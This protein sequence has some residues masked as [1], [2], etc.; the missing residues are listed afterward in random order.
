MKSSTIQHYRWLFFNSA[1]QPFNF[2]CL[3]PMTSN[4]YFIYGEKISFFHQIVSTT[5]LSP[6]NWNVCGQHWPAKRISFYEL[7]RN[8]KSR[9]NNFGT[10]EINRVVIKSFSR[11]KMVIRLFKSNG[12]PSSYRWQH[13]SRTYPVAHCHQKENKS[14]D[15]N[16]LT[17][18]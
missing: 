11:G 16:N 15:S 12:A 6:K 1:K 5:I 8:D 14:T 2:V 18:I 10:N 9:T 17:F 13:W 3:T 4:K 7:F